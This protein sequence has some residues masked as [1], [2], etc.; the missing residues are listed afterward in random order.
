[1]KHSF[2]M[3]LPFTLIFMSSA[4]SCS[5]EDDHINT[6]NDT[7]MATGK[8]SVDKMISAVVPLSEGASW[9]NRLYNKEPG[10]NKVILVPA[11]P[12]PSEGGE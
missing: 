5:K 11:S 9:F 1:M 7:I 10:L 3:I 2:F 6:A 8:I 4:S 12:S